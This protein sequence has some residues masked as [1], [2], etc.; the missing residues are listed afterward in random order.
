MYLDMGSATSSSNHN[1]WMVVTPSL[2][3]EFKLEWEAKAIIDDVDH[4]EI[5]SL[6]SRLNKQSWYQQRLIEQ[7]AGH[8]QELEATL[9]CVDGYEKRRE[10]YGKRPWWKRLL[11]KDR[12]FFVVIRD[13]EVRAF[14]KDQDA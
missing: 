1:D 9:A 11:G 5:A 4:R 2:E 7:A 14:M 8:I 13:E 6:C 3:Q 10:K 12:L